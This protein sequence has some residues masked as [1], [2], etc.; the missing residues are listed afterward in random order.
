MNVTQ[1]IGDKPRLASFDAWLRAKPH[2][3][4]CLWRLHLDGGVPTEADLDNCYQLLLEECGAKEASSEKPNASFPTVEL[5]QP[6]EVRP[7]RSWLTKID[8]P[9]NVNAIS[10]DAVIDFGRS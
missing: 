6:G 5:P 10:G 7:A 1:T 2:W 3:E 8:N 9:R 4:Q